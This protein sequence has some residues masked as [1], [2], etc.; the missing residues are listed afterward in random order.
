MKIKI[1][2]KK[3][4]VCVLKVIIKVIILFVKMQAVLQLYITSKHKMQTEKKRIC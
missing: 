1:T 3:Q 4:F 2:F